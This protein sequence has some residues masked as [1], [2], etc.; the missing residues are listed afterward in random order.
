MIVLA[1][2]NSYLS[3]NLCRVVNTWNT[4]KLLDHVNQE[5]KMVQGKK[6]NEGID[7]FGEVSGEV[8]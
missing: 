4:E 7:I 5:K 3:E 2:G 8:R 1:F 6:L